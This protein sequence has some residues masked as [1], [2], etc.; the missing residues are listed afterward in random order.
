MHAH[1]AR[2]ARDFIE[3]Y[4]MEQ[5]PHPPS[6]PDLA[7]S[8]FHLFGYLKDRLQQQHFD[9]GDQPFDVIIAL[10][11]RIVKVTLQR[12]FLERMERVRRCIDTNGEYVG[13]PN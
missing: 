5:A 4:G 12:M 7:R 8:D 3:T 10:T 2:R 13:G 9:D 6:S 1:A 11:R